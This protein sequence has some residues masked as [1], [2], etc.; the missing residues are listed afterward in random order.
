MKKAGTLILII[1]AI[2]SYGEARERARVRQVQQSR[3]VQMRKRENSP[4]D[5][6]EIHE[7]QE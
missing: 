1:I 3:I 6:G 2:F 5:S 7:H 4:N